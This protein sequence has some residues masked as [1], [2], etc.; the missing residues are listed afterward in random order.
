MYDRFAG[1]PER[2]LR[3]LRRA[4]ATPGSTAAP[5]WCGWP[6]SMAA[7]WA[8]SPM[9]PV[10]ETLPRARVFLRLTLRSIPP[11]RWPAA[12]RLYRAGARAAP[13]PARR[14]VLRRRAGGRALGAQAAAWEGRCSHMPRSRRGGAG[15]PAIAL[16]TALDNQA[17][18]ALYLGAGFEEVAYRAPGRRAARVRVAGQAA[19]AEPRGPRAAPAATRSTCASASSGKKG[20]ASDRA[21]HVLADR[22]LALAVAEAL[23]V[24]AH[25]VDRRQVGLGV[26]AALAQRLHGG[27]AV[28]ASRA[29]AP[30]RRTSCAGRRPRPGRAARVP[31]C[32]RAPGSRAP[33]RGARPESSSSSRSSCASPSAHERSSRR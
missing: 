9:F 25:Q 12:L 1:G 30:R 23:A 8:P 17:A 31:R 20:S 5:R 18:R 29:A 28:G 33:P 15:L 4:L 14:H 6:S 13:P 21:R 16:D 10:D 2:A 26:H 7:R 11:W 19:R 32:P 24:E 22:E 3:L 27:V